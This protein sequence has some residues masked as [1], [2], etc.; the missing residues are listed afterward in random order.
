MERE[1]KCV[2]GQVS[3]KLS[4]FLGPTEK[5]IKALNGVEELMDQ[6]NSCWISAFTTAVKRRKWVSKED[7]KYGYEWSTYTDIEVQ[8]QPVP[9]DPKREE[10]YKARKEEEE[11]RLRESKKRRERYLRK[12]EEERKE[13]EEILAS[14][15][16]KLKSTLFE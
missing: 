15:G 14:L 9:P 12:K 13:R 7:Q 16:D 2:Q 5:L 11:R 1:L 8:I 6:R 10:N 3:F 4:D